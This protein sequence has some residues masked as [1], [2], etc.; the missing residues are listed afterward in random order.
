MI[1]NCQQKTSTP[2]D[3][4]RVPIFMAPAA[5]LAAGSDPLT[6]ATTLVMDLGGSGLAMAE[7]SRKRWSLGHGA[8]GGDYIGG[9]LSKVYWTSPENM[10]P[11]R[12]R[13][14][15]ATCICGDLQW[16]FN[17]LD[18][19]SLGSPPLNLTL[20]NA[21]IIRGGNAFIQTLSVMVWP[22]SFGETG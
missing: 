6:V 13:M 18:S 7:G 20:Y 9:V 10:D 1:F 17:G 5:V 21:N 11:K 22:S 19:F 16:D 12:E 3:P 15:C 4:Q 2:G 8:I 14:I